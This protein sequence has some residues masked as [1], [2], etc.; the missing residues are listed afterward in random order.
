M[1]ILKVSAVYALVLVASTVAAM[2]LLGKDPDTSV[3]QALA[4]ATATGGIIGAIAGVLK[5]G[6]GPGGE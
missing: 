6:P 2:A 5:V 3:I 4:V 1:R